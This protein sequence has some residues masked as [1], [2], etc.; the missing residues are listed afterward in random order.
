MVQIKTKISLI[1]SKT[2][3]YYSCDK[4]HKLIYPVKG[5]T[6]S[7]SDARFTHCTWSFRCDCPPA[8]KE[9]K[10]EIQ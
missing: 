2:L 7:K 9:G 3:F 10:N 1:D 6:G 8:L 5:I 4:L